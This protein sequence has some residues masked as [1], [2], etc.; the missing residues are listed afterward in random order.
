M[1]RFATFSSLYRNGMHPSPGCNT[2]LSLSQM[3]SLSQGPLA[4]KTCP[5]LAPLLRRSKEFNTAVW[6]KPGV[7]TT[8]LVSYSHIVTQ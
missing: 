6:V 4:W 1:S 5:P 7:F 3:S 8:K 2:H